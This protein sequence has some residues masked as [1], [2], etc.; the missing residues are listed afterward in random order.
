MSHEKDTRQR[1]T[2]S[3]GDRKRRAYRPPRSTALTRLADA[4]VDAYY[5]LQLEQHELLREEKGWSK[6]LNMLANALNEAAYAHWETA[7][8]Y[9]TAQ[10]FR[11]DRRRRHPDRLTA[12]LIAW[13]KA[14]VKKA[15]AALARFKGRR[16]S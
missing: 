6:K 16:R 2:C 12:K 8:A 1:A 5:K 15:E 9:L 7:Q 3:Y 10:E 4:H 14:R 13:N 11:G